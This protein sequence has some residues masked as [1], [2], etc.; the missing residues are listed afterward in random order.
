MKKQI[1]LIILLSAFLTATAQ[2]QMELEE[3]ADDHD[4]MGMSVVRVCGSDIESYHFGLKD[5]TRQLVVDDSTM[6]RIASI[7]K[8]VTAMGLMNLWEDGA[9]G[10]DDDV[11]AALGFEL[12]NPDFP[13]T[14][15]TYRMLLSHQSSIQDGSGY[16]DFLSA[17]YSF[18]ATP[19]SISELLTVSGEYYSSNMFRNEEPGT[20]FAYSNINYGI[21]G[22]LIEALSGQRFDIYMREAVLEPLG[23]AGSYN[24][25]DIQNID[26]VAVLYRYQGGWN[27]QADNYQ[28]VPP[29]PLSLQAYQN[30][31]N[32]VIFAP[33]G[34]LRISPTDLA[35]LLISLQHSSYNGIAI[36]EPATIE[37]MKTVQWAYDG[38]NGDNYYGL[39]RSWGLGIQVTTDTS[40]G[41]R[42]CAGSTF[43][44]HPG[45]AYGLISDMYWFLN[46]DTDAGFIFMTNGSGEGFEFGS[47]SA[48][49]SLEEEVFADLCNYGFDGC[50]LGM[51][52]RNEA[53]FRV[54]PNPAD[55]LV[56]IKGSE[57]DQIL[58]CMN[59]MGS[60]FH[61]DFQE[62]SDGEFIMD[63]SELA[64]GFYYIEI[65]SSAG[66]LE[67]F[68]VSI[69]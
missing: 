3:I 68:P 19:P 25:G 12:R 53:V 2:W 36:L 57:G 27:P 44:G 48:Y 47:E 17:T 26:N 22:T 21:I 8:T 10:L 20:Y 9:F 56:H 6:Y 65:L 42:I 59:A 14:P 55:G 58:R 5:Y 51:D 46:P 49:Y 64:A 11:S 31:T 38:N 40:G 7:S 52:E 69:L 13:D 61:P 1:S 43:M 18:D 62:V 60:L 32:G 67:R 24:V 33:Q 39:F 41:D 28:G 37:Q 16:N 35:R 29:V 4:L 50:Y 15:I 34:G 23:I 30:G 45:E 63:T 54:W 66:K